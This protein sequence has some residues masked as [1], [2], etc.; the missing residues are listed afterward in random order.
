MKIVYCMEWSLL[1]KQPHNILSEEDAKERY[2]KEES[3]VSVIYENNKVKNVIEIDEISITV[4]FYNDSLENYLLYGFIK[5]DDKL[6]LNTAYHY[7]YK[8]SK[9][10]EHI[11]FNF[12]EN[13]EM[14]IEKRDFITGNVEERDGIVDV[15]CNW[16]LFPD[17]GD[18]H[19]L[20]RVNRDK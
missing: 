8:E 6:F 16:E 4:R 10:V 12:K 5:K 19:G 15:S 17:F 1:K 18:Y 3:Y 11:L 7:T 14:F 20:I 2:I 9:K 13:G